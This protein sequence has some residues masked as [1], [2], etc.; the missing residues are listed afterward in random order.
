MAARAAVDAPG[1]YGPT[2]IGLR[3]AEERGESAPAMPRRTPEPA[4]DRGEPARTTRP[5]GQTGATPETEAGDARVAAADTPAE[6]AGAARTHPDRGAEYGRGRPR[7]QPRGGTEN[8]PENEPAAGYQG[9]DAGGPNAADAP[10]TERE[11]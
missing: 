10:T 2:L 3:L 7:K 11:A 6:K 5:T 9:P 8:P 1:E 4:P